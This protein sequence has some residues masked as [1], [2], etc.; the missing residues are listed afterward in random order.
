MDTPEIKQNPRPKMRHEIILTIKDAPGP[1]ES[2]EGRMQYDVVNKNCAPKDEWTGVYQTPPSQYPPIVFS[3]IS[4]YVYIGGLYLDML[5]DEDYF[6]LGACHWSMFSAQVFLKAKAIIFDASISK[7]DLLA[8]NSAV[9]Y[10]HKAS[11]FSESKGQEMDWDPGRRQGTPVA[12]SAEQ[13]P[14]DYF[15]ATLVAREARQ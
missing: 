11:Y 12:K 2:V 7:N 8:G 13:H 4:D 14:N 9:I 6:G 1:F 10:F 5:E 15:T 3:K